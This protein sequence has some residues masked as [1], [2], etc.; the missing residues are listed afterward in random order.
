M[1]FFSYYMDPRIISLHTI[2]GP[3]ITFFGAYYIWGPSDQFLLIQYGGPSQV[4]FIL[5]YMGPPLRSVSL[6]AIG[7]GGGHHRFQFF[8]KI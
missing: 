8:H 5:Y 1:S 2:F 7:G 3:Q 6:H 4:S